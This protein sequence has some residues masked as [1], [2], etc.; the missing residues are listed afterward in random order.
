MMET[1]LDTTRAGSFQLAGIIPVG[2]QPLDFNLPWH[3]CLMPLEPNY[4]AVQHA[5]MECAWA[6]CETIWIVCHENMRP[7]VRHIVGE[8]VYDPVW[9]G[10]KH[11]IYPKQTRK[12]IPI[13][14]V[15][16]H[17]K[18]KDKRDCLG[19]SVIHGAQ[20]AYWTAKKVSAWLV[21][22]RYYVS[23]PYGVYKNESLRKHRKDISSKKRF[24]LR[25]EEGTIR[26][27]HYLGFTFD[28]EDFKKIRQN[29]RAEGTGIRV[30]GTGMDGEKLP[31]EE[32]WSGRYFTLDKVFRDVI[33]DKETVVVDLDWYHGIDNWES[34]CSYLASPYRIKIARP[35]K[36][37]MDYRE[38][39]GIGTEKD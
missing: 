22:D 21:P 2:G 23:F 9:F 33:I 30:P 27:G 16:V 7:L 6:G 39:N 8:Y 12:L 18:D 28:A 14:Y 19:W 5:V 3:D 34:Y 24:V 26:D 37:I 32:R 36:G 13:Y 10:R 17:P 20:S 29:F 31:V 4:H 35:F 15:P 11:D 38:F 25:S 1:E